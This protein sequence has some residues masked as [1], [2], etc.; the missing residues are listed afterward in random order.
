[1]SKIKKYYGEKNI[2]GQIIKSEREKQ[3]IPGTELCAKLALRGISM[4]KEELLRVENN[5]LLIKDFELVAIFDILNIDLNILKS[6]VQL[7]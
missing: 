3:N 4:E 6:C 2:A 5:Q 7:N 1:M